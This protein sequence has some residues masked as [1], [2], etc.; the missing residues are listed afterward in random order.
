M[1]NTILTVETNPDI[2]ERLIQK[3]RVRE[4]VRSTA[5]EGIVF[6]SIGGVFN[7]SAKRREYPWHLRI[8]VMNCLD[9]S[10]LGNIRKELLIQD[11]IEE[12]LTLLI[13][14]YAKIKK[15]VSFELDGAF[16]HHW[17]LTKAQ[18][19]L[20]PDRLE[21]FLDLNEKRPICFDITRDERWN[22]VAPYLEVLKRKCL[23]YY[24]D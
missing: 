13:G 5:L 12:E 10:D 17:Y 1:Q 7:S 21:K 11:T 6:N 20:S 4:E 2:M 16:E 8:K 3:P 22:N 23:T 18:M 9:L 19:K 15:V 14:A 24:N